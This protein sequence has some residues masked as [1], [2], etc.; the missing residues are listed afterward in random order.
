[1]ERTAPLGWSDHRTARPLI[2]AFVISLSFHVGVFSTVELGSRWGLWRFSPLGALARMLNLDELLQ[3]HASLEANH[4][5]PAELKKPGEENE[6]PLLFVDVDPAQA[7][8]DVPAKTPY[9]S[10]FNSLAANPDTSRD[11]GVPRIDGSQDKVLKTKDTIRARPA[12]RPL[13]P[14]PAKPEEAQE[15]AEH[16]TLKPIV[17]QPLKPEPAPEA[18]HLPGETLLARASLVPRIDSNPS[19]A[20]QIDAAPAQR[21]RIRRV[22][23][24]PAAKELNPGSALEGEKMK[25]E[26]GVKRFSISSSLDVRGSPLG[27]YDAQ[28]IAAVQQCWFQLLEAHRYSLDRLGKV[29]LDFRLTTDGRITE[30]KV[31]DTDVGEIFTTVCE[32][33]VSKPAPY[34]K[35]PADVRKMIGR[36][37]RDVRFTFYY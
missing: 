30:M 2:L 4:A 37:Y 21:A 33:A 16:E 3:K 24:A 8:T 13:Q 6:M 20:P 35:W 9:Y 15:G 31:A 1:M 36:D 26:G 23:D 22:A 17:A 29:V 12:A 14:A 7:T 5:R 18:A 28:F 32:L 11:L 27:S 34:E 25:Q 19:T 10:P